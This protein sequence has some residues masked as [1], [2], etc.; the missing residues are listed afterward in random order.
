MALM[1]EIYFCVDIET[2][3]PCP[4]KNSLLSVGVVALDY[5]MTQLGTFYVTVEPLEGS[6]DP[7]TMD[8]W[9]DFPEAWEK[10]TANQQPPKRAMED[11][12]SFVKDCMSRSEL[13]GPHQPVFVAQPAGFDFSFIYYYLHA[14]LGDCIFGHRA[15]DMRSLACGLTG[16]DYMEAS[17]R[18]YPKGWKTTLP[19]THH[20][21]DDAMEQAEIFAKMMQYKA[22][23]VCPMSTTSYALASVS[24]R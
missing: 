1:T 17:K 23:L 3:G 4:G 9:K 15:L 7:R 10:A 6:P 19:H 11:L 20:A 14:Y 18:N 24:S 2:N 13:P 21:L 16:L 5:N 22:V 8:W 12:V